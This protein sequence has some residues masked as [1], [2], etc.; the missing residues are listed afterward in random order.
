[1]LCYLDRGF[2]L[3]KAFCKAP[4]RSTSGM[5]VMQSILTRNWTGKSRLTAEMMWHLIVARDMMMKFL[6]P[7]FHTETVPFIFLSLK[8]VRSIGRPLFPVASLARAVRLT[9]R[10]LQSWASVFFMSLYIEGDH[11]LLCR[12]SRVGIATR[13][14]LDGPEIE[15]SWGRVFLCPPRPVFRPT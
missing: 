8:L 11:K 5:C 3:G 15:S 14:G 1:M 13:Y 9:H 2:T 7:L 6:L 4:V 12:R 10:K